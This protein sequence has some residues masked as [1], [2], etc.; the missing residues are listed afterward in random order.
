MQHSM[1]TFRLHRTAVI[2]MIV[3]A[4]FAA[5][6]IFV[7]G[8]F[9][10]MRGRGSGPVPVSVPPAAPTK[11]APP[12]PPK[13]DLLAVRVGVFDS[14]DEAKVLAQQL[15][16]R[17]LETAIVPITTTGGVKLFTVQVGQYATR[18]E[19][20]AAASSLAEEPGLQPAVVPAGR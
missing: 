7:A 11:S 9:L 16:A 13:P 17:K 1:V 3:G 18:A 5:V 19:A 10:A 20:A 14:E 4:V 15:A 12:P 2:F 6:L 8:Y